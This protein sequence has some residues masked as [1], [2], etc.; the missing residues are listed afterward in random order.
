MK[1]KF[2]PSPKADQKVKKE[3]PVRLASPSPAVPAQPAQR[4][5]SMINSTPSAQRIMSGPALSP[6]GQLPGPPGSNSFNGTQAPHHPQGHPQGQHLVYPGPPPALPS[7]VSQHYMGASYSP[8][9]PKPPAVGPQILGYA[10]NGIS[11]PTQPVYPPPPRNY[12]ANTHYNGGGHSP[13][14]TLTPNG[15]FSAYPP[16]QQAPA[17]QANHYGQHRPVSSQSNQGFQYHPPPAAAPLSSP[18]GYAMSANSS[19]SGT[20]RVF[21]PPN[22]YETPARASLGPHQIVH[23]ANQSPHYSQAQETALQGSSPG[24]SPMKQSSPPPR[25]YSSHSMSERPVVPPVA[26]SPD[27]KPQI[28]S[29]PVKKASPVLAHD[30]SPNGNGFSRPNGQVSDEARGP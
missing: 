21:S 16:A 7:V 5:T 19:F 20:P 22:V 28:R 15:S 27:E 1:L 6:Q 26:L 30:F 4:P 17:Q 13:P 18:N 29:P 14:N 23:Q 10:P 11:A 3:K 8:H 12:S 24:Y 9:V 2:G 25:P